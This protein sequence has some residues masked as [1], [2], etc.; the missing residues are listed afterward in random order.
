MNSYESTMK[1]STVILLGVILIICTSYGPPNCNLF[2][3]D[4]GCYNACL[5]AER[6]IEYPQGSKLSQELFDKSIQLCPGFDY[7]YY[8]KSVPYAK[9]GLIKE[10]KEMIDIALKID[11]EEHLATRGWFHFF[12]MHNYEAAIKDIEALEQLVDYDIGYSGDGT[13]HLNIIKALCWKGL[14]KTEKAI[15]II[16][17]Q[18]NKED[19]DLGMYDYLHLGVLHYQNEE[20]DLALEYLEKQ[21]DENDVSEIYYYKAL[22]LKAQNKFRMYK[23]SIQKA[24]QYYDAGTTMSNSYRQMEDEIYKVDLEREIASTDHF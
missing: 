22:C 15:E 11:P 1:K 12:F 23:Q 19:H 14:G 6:A 7:S 24:L 8:E 5:E 3:A 2:K 10:W 13:Y 16:T 18:L 20:Y 21:I 17:E 9:R 4:E